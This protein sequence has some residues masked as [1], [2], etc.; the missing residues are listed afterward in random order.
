MWKLILELVARAKNDRILALVAAGP[1]ETISI[2]IR[3]I[4]LNLSTSKLEKIRNLENASHGY[5][6]A[7]YRS[8]CGSGSTQP[9]RISWVDFQG[10]ICYSIYL[11]PKIRSSRRC[12][13]LYINSRRPQSIL[14]HVPFFFPFLAF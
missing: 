12:H 8:P 9:G 4:S 5:G 6:E 11:M 13:L 2:I 7:L 1:L 10:K 14:V 3:K